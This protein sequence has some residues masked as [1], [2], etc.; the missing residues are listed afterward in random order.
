MAKTHIL[1]A[2][3][4]IEFLK[5][6][7]LLLEGKGY[8][9]KTVNNG[10]DAVEAFKNEPFDLV[11]LDENMPGMTGL[12][13][14]SILKSI[15]PTIPNVLVTKNEEE[16]LMEEAIGAKIDEIGRAHV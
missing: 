9:V 12:E 2:D 16:H 8:K 6:H 13:T 14:L 15:N 3:D 7:I 5:P 4:E 11:F 10:A 1:W